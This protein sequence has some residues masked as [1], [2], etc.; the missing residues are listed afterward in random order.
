MFACNDI[1]F[2]N[3]SP[4]RVETFV[5]KKITQTLAKIA[6]GKQKKL[7]LGNL[8][9]KHDWGF[10]GDYV[11]AMWLM[12][13]QEKPDNYVIA[14]GET[15]TVREF[16][17]EAFTLIGLNWKDYV[18][19]DPRYYRPLEVDVLRGDASKAK[20]K[21]K[22]EPTI[23]FKDLVRLMVINDLDEEGFDTTKL[24][25]TSPSRSS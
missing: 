12:L 25:K 2:N 18:G 1:L 8:D 22:W 13:Q 21:L 20:K 19:I 9:A 24:A 14:T 15:H 3:E 7:Y 23:R 6:T 17:N 11:E 4:R 16:L 10:A 5:T